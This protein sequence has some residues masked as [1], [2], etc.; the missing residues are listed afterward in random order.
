[1]QR[2]LLAFLL[3]GAAVR[4]QA[5]DFT[6]MWYNPAQPGYGFN[7]VQSD[8][9][10][11]RPYIFVPFFIYGPNNAPTWY[12]AGLTWDGVDSFTGNV[13]A[14]T[15]TF[16]GVPWNTADYH[17]TQVG[18]ATFKPN[19]IYQGTFSYTVTN[20]GSA[21]TP[22]ERQT[23]TVN[24][25]GGNYI[26]AEIDVYTG[27]TDPIN[28]GE[29]SYKYNLAI[30]QLKSGDVTFVFDYGNGFVCTL[31]GIL[32][33]HGQYYVGPNATFVC[34]DGTNTVAKVADLKATALGIEAR[35][36][37]KSDAGGC[38]IAITFSALLI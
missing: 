12:V 1:M 27:C 22:L 33:Q 24:A 18:T 21:T 5:V 19:N 32:E 29:V 36:L 28:D 34:P 37:V 16:F 26:G 31:D 11:G 13:Y 8:D 15:G 3:L 35:Y 14:G 2:L 6:D 30:T 38:E 20:V 10:S 17:A 23:L 9:G 7:V 25:L 4:A